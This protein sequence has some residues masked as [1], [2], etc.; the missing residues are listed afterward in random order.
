MDPLVS[1]ILPAY[2]SEKFIGRSLGSALAQSYRR[3]EVVVIDDGSTDRT[4]KLVEEFADPRIRYLWQ[5]NAGQGPARN[6]GMRQCT[7]DYITFLDADDCYLPTKVE[8]E[9]EFLE[10]H[11]H[12]RVA[13]CGVRF[14]YSGQA[15]RLLKVKSKG[16]SGNI[17]PELMRD[18]FINP[19]AVMLAREVWERVGGFNETRYFPEEWE[20]YL[21]IALAGYEFGFI[22]ED[23][24]VVESRPGSNT[25]MAIQPQLKRNAIEMLERLMP[26]PVVV[27]NIKCSVAPVVREMRLKLALAHLANSERREFLGAMGGLLGSRLLGY[28]AGLPLLV[29]PAAA[30]R[31]VWSCNMRLRSE[32]VYTR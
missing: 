8:R 32:I 13:Y 15:D 24:V 10:R 31:A 19:N 21:R 3:L 16:R 6:R 28:L 30:V 7:G 12:Y 18:S 26:K 29:V 2:N 14:F 23:L 5:A 1:V 17:L 25:T 4:R 9:V 22:D 20:L 11:S 27:E